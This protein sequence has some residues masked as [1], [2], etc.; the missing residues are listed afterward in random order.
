MDYSMLLKPLIGA[1]IG[2]STNWLAIK[3]LFKPHT[4]VRI[5][6]IKVPFTPG[7]IPRERNRIAKSLGGAVGDRLL[8]KEVISKELLNEGV[9]AQIK[10]YITKDLL[11]KPRS[12]KEIMETVLGDEYPIVVNK[13]G[14]GIAREL[15][16]KIASKDMNETLYRTIKEYLAGRLSYNTALDTVLPST[17][18]I[19]LEF[20]LENHKEQICDYI[21]GQIRQPQVEDKV[22][23]IVG[24]LI[25]EKV[26]AL[27]AMF[28]NSKEV[29]TSILDYIEKTLHEEEVQK[30]LIHAVIKSANEVMVNPISDILAL[31]QYEEM[32]ESATAQ[33]VKSTYGLMNK[34]SLKDLI[35]SMMYPLLEK[36]ILLTTHERDQIE[37]KI[38]MLYIAFVE[39]NIGTFLENFEVAKIVENEVNDFSVMDIERLIF[40]IVDKELNAITWFGAL[41]GFVMGIVYIFI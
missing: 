29:T 24:E 32:L 13:I 9:I 20:I 10:A 34:I 6:K 5:G 30:T 19:D 8:T 40:A 3:M 26:G 33:I 35:T 18:W 12:L 27:G 31:R 28:L 15:E 2:Y 37:S 22:N 21:I 1:L 11:G 4:E 41:L 17:V 25:H 16:D 38:E 7:V 39:N 23:L 14:K 36:K